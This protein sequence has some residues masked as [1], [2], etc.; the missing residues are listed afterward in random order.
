MRSFC[1]EY[2]GM[3][4]DLGRISPTKNRPCGRLLVLLL[5]FLVYLAFA[6]IGVVLLELDLALYLLLILA[7]A[8]D[9][10]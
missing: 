1:S 3:Y 5:G 8:A 2:G 10:A 7:A 4:T 9:V 6:G